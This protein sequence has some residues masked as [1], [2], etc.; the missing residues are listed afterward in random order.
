MELGSNE[1]AEKHGSKKSEKENPASKAKE[2]E[3]E[4]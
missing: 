2:A 4:A 3:A 1:E